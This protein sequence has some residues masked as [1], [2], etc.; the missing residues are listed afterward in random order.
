MI[1]HSEDD[2]TIPI[3]YGY[4]LYSEKYGNDSRF[5]FKKYTDRGH[6]VLTGA[7]GKLDT[8]LMGEIVSFFD[9]C[10]AEK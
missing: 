10:I 4:E 7:D 2:E 9:A 1:V 3:G 8:A 6:G 5:T